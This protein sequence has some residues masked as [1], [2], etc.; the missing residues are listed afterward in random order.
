MSYQMCSVDISVNRQPIGC[1]FKEGFSTHRF[2]MR[3]LNF[4]LQFEMGHAMLVLA[5]DLDLKF[6]VKY[7]P[8]FGKRVKF[9]SN[10]RV[11]V[12]W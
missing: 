7:W 6:K 1:N 5:F 4:Q 11:L 8:K 9:N 3:G 10:D 12:W 2:G